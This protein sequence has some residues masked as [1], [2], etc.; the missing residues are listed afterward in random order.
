MK[1]SRRSSPAR[2]IVSSLVA[3]V[4][5]F[6]GIFG[7]IY[8]QDI[9]DTIAGYGYAPTAGISQIEDRVAL[10]QK[11]ARIFHAT[12]PELI[13]AEAFNAS[14]PR[15]E[16]ASPIIG[17]YT[18]R[19]AIFI[20]DITDEKL[21]GIK[22]VTAV[23]ELLHAVWVRM[24]NDERDRIGGL[25]EQSYRDNSSDDLKARMEYYDR[26]EAGQTR[27]ELHSILGTEVAGLS[28]EL[29]AHYAQYFNRN[30]VTDLYSKYQ[31]QYDA[32]EAKVADLQAE[33]TA[34]SG[35][36]TARNQVYERSARQLDADIAAFNS[37]ARSGSFGVES[38]FNAERARLMGRSS[39]LERE[40]QQ[41]NTAI[42]TYNDRYAAYRDV[43]NEIQALNS[44][45]DSF[46]ELE[47]A[48][49]VENE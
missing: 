15:Q 48:K 4:L 28:P 1:S 6:A 8:R 17:C 19:D 16:A 3:A 20:Y 32:L 40:R 10:T 2:V 49:T 44:S 23:H 33:L 45:I 35:N 30:L 18:T 47:P 9:Q 25:L 36:I 41:I 21:D 22:E 31:G 43:A 5:L 12:S 34:L 42:E 26:T 11:G 13:S 27:N 39:T 38:Q 46:T 29:E 14:C 7:F 24:S 37:R